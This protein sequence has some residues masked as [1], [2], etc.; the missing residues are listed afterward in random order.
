[1]MKTGTQTMTFEEAVTI[2]KQ[3]S[4]SGT[5]LLDGLT[6]VKGILNDIDKGLLNEYSLSSEDKTA[7]RVVCREMSKLFV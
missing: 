3:F 4:P 6:N 7:F 2:M 5:N 1:M